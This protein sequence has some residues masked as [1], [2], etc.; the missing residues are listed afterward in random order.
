MFEILT[1]VSICELSNQDLSTFGDQLC[2]V[3]SK[4]PNPFPLQLGKALKTNLV[5]VFNKVI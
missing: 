1:N 3:H 2:T 4:S 5:E